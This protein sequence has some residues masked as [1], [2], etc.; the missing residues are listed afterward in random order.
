M[1]SALPQL[2]GL[3][4]I[5]LARGRKA[6]S[7][8]EVTLSL[9]VMAVAILP[10]IALLPIGLQMQHAANQGTIETQVLQRLTAHYEST[11]FKALEELAATGPEDWHFNV[12]GQIVDETDFARLYDARVTVQYPYEMP[13]SSGGTVSYLPNYSAAGL[14]V[15]IVS[16]PALR[17]TPFD[18][19]EG[20]KPSTKHTVVYR[21]DAL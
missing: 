10:V 16:N 17:S 11:E 20:M 2:S 18:E 14:L 7:L 21:N 12:D 15:E 5:G 1:K 6:F 19:Q 3:A 9:G 13:V 4:R 8:V